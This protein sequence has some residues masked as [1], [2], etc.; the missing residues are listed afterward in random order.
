M[1]F[2]DK[3]TSNWYLSI[4]SIDYENQFIISSFL[5]TSLFNTLLSLPKSART[6]LSLSTFKLSILVYRLAKSVSDA[7]IDA[8]MT[9]A[10]FNTGL[11][12]LVR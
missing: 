3:F 1:C 7:I 12:C 9:D 10:P 6:V 11:R 2:S 8:S 5:T 4:N